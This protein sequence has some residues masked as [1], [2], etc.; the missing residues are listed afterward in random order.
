MEG[1]DSLSAGE[2]ERCSVP[3]QEAVAL[4]RVPESEFDAGMDI[5]DS[6]EIKEWLDRAIPTMTA[7]EKACIVYCFP[8]QW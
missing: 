6:E 2:L 7:L 8:Y 1:I 4:N 5:E 3:Y